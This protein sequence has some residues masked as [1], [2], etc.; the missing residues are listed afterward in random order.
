MHRI[1]ELDKA[2]AECKR[3]YAGNGPCHVREYLAARY[4][5]HKLLVKH[6]LLNARLADQKPALV[7][8]A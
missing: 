1:G 3:T 8:P 5:Y 4:N 6:G 2:L 7:G